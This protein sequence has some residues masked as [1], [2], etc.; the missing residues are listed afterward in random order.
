MDIWITA[1][2]KWQGKKDKEM[3]IRRTKCRD[4]GI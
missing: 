1:R 3:D 2:K 4:K